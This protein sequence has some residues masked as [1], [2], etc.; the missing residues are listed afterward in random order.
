[1]VEGLPEGLTEEEIDAGYASYT[2]ATSLSDDGHDRIYAEPDV[3][4]SLEQ[5]ASLP[6]TFCTLPP[7]IRRQIYLELPDLV[8][9]YPLIYC[10]ST[11]A[12]K[13]QHPLAAVSRL[14]RAEALAIFYGYNTWIVKLEF[15][16][17][18]EAF[19]NWIICL[20]E[21]ASLLRIVHIAV[22]GSLFKP[23]TSHQPVL[24]FVPANPPNAQN[25]AQN[26]PEAAQD[27]YQPPDGDA[28]FKI[29]LSEKYNGGRVEL[30]RNDGTP[31]AGEMGRVHLGKLVQGLWEKKCAG[32]LN[33]QDWI[34]MVDQFLNFVGWRVDG[35]A[36][37]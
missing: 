16:M 25:Q 31:E 24:S 21:D 11:F 7:E 32:T 2:S 12:N 30:L 14:V 29:D 8:L 13:K 9:P 23:R 10:L 6:V 4:P 18:Y 36:T 22:R 37:M 17:M 34:T 3:L 19:Q 1:M 20:G 26:A 28:C 15:N 33:G 35:G 5:V 27:G